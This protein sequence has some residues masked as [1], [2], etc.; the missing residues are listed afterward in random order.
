MQSLWLSLAVTNSCFFPWNWDGLKECVLGREWWV[1][2]ETYMLLPNKGFKGYL[3]VRKRKKKCPTS[4]RPVA[5]TGLQPEQDGA[6]TP[7]C[8]LLL[9]CCGLWWIPASRLKY[10]GL[11]WN[12][13]LLLPNTKPSELFGLLAWCLFAEVAG[14]LKSPVPYYRTLPSAWDLFPAWF[15]LAPSSRS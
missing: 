9:S 13:G 3:A 7:Q 6:N 11:A 12:S 15:F 8:S 4:C 10:Q 2:K 5:G 1:P 14:N